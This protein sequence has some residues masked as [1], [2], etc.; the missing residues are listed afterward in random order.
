[1][2]T[3]IAYINERFTSIANKQDAFFLVWP[4]GRTDMEICKNEQGKYMQIYWVKDE[5]YDTFLTAY[6]FN[7]AN[8]IKNLASKLEHSYTVI[9]KVTGFTLE[10]FETLCKNRD[11]LYPSIKTD[12]EH[13][14]LIFNNLK[15]IKYI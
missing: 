3:L 2:K 5:K 1:M 6:I 9:F 7:T 8:S 4:I 11:F 14:T 10:E 15:F 13:F 12:T